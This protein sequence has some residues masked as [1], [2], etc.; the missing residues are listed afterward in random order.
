MNACKR[1]AKNHD[2]AC[3][4]KGQG[5]YGVFYFYERRETCCSGKGRYEDRFYVNFQLLETTVSSSEWII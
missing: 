3:Q 4:G 2:V 1:R 5:P